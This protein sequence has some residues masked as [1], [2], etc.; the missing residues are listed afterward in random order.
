[1]T[2]SCDI[3]I[4]DPRWTDRMDVETVV[5]SVVEK[6]LQV[7]KVRLSHEAEASFTF[8][9]DRRIHELNA[10]WRQKDFPTNV[11]SFPATEGAALHTS[12]LLGDV[13]LAYETIAREAIDE[14]KAFAHHAAH[15]IAHGFLHLIGF[16]H[17]DDAQ[18]DE[19][20]GVESKVLS[21]LGIPDPWAPENTTGKTGQ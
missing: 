18:A 13:V 11:L 7:T 5:N 15:M 3:L 9:D 1:M 21:T 16:D 6:A 14:G 8:A 2:V 17:Q 10:I 4:D 12:P 19:M 20:E